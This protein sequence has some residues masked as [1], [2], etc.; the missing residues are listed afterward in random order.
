MRIL[1]SLVANVFAL[2]ATT[3]VPGIHFDVRGNIFLLI[4]AG[5]VFALFNA[6]VRPIAVI[7]S[8]PFLIVTLGLFYF[9]LNGILLYAAALLIPGYRVDGLMAGI[10]GGLVLM[11]VNWFLNALRRD[12]AAAREA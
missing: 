7:L 6:I 9:V 1:L 8:I 2:W 3:I 5:V 11:V 12:A 4:F 10:L